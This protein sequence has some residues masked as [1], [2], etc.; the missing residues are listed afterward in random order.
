ME[1]ASKSGFKFHLSQDRH[2]EPLCDG[3][4]LKFKQVKI[5]SGQTPGTFM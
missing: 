5:K 3:T 4:Y 2:P 1:L